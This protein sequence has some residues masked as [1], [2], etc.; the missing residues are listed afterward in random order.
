MIILGFIL[1]GLI[2]YLLMLPKL[3]V[4]KRKDDAIEEVNENLKKELTLLQ[5]QLQDI[6]FERNQKINE[7]DKV[8]A[9]ISEE[10]ESL[11]L[12]SE[13]LK[14]RIEV[15]AKQLSQY[16]KNEEESYQ[17]TYLNSLEEASK[18][19]SNIISLK[20]EEI[21]QL[22]EE[23]ETLR[24]I[25]AAAIEADKRKLEKQENDKFY[26]VILTPIDVEEIKKIRE[27][28][29]LLR[30]VEPLNKVI[31]KVYYEKPFSAMVGRVVGLTPITGIYKITNLK[32]GMCY[33]G[34]A[35]DIAAR[36]KQHVKR[37]IGA[38]T[39]T[40]NKLYP[41]MAE[42]GVENF[43]FE[44][45]EQC[46]KEELNVREIFWQDYFKAKEFGYSIK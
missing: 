27:V 36:W 37:G 40:R 20:K 44:I 39:P 17:Q 22:T 7:L 14:D 28:S 26:R 38:E 15:Q 5:Q 3:K 41:A 18:D 9:S 43:S 25:T 12:M 10:K 2:I 30:N 1:G 19:F 45:I 8:V 16:Y 32:N 24:Q 34:Q 33:V 11:K 35:V 4:T 23:F 46:S 31:W 42:Y 13:H 21:K 6:L 29:L